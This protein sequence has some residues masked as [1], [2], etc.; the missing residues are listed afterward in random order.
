MDLNIKELEKQI[1]MYQKKVKKL[2]EEN[3]EINKNI[4]KCNDAYNQVSKKIENTESV[5]NKRLSEI[6]FV[7]SKLP[8]GSI[9]GDS[10]YNKLKNILFGKN[11]DN[12]LADLRN[13]Q[14]EIKRKLDNFDEKIINNNNKI[15]VYNSKIND[16]KI[17]ISRYEEGA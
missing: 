16:L 1:E 11:T 10:Y 12:A 17:M 3:R 4:D 8:L 2:N 15:S 9:F 14:K 5:Y 13:T 7:M 6:K